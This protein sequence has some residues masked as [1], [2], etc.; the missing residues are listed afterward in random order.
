MASEENYRIWQKN[1]ATLKLH[2]F[3]QQHDLLL[4]LQFPQYFGDLTMRVFSSEIPTI[5]FLELMPGTIRQEKS[6]S[7]SGWEVRICH[8]VSKKGW[9]ISPGLCL[10]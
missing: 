3:V 9:C 6:Q 4:L 1:P 5:P 8:D 2:N 7:I 10:S